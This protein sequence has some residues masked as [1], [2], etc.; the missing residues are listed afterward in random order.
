MTPMGKATR[1]TSMSSP[2]LSAY[3]I[4]LD[5][6]PSASN[7]SSMITAIIE[8]QI[9]PTHYSVFMQIEIATSLVFIKNKPTQAIRP[10]EMSTAKTGLIN[11]D[12]TILPS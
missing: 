6:S 12:S 10:K 5:V 11:Q 2:I 7:N 9:P 8:K 1:K 4:P 3:S